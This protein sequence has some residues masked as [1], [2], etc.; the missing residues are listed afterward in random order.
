MNTSLSA[1]FLC[2]IFYSHMKYNNH[3]NVYNLYISATIITTMPSILDISSACLTK[4]IQYFDFATF[5]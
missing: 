5:L 4:T 1:N 3:N 2:Y